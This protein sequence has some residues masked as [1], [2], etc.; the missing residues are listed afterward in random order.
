MQIKIFMKEN[1]SF[2]GDFKVRNN[3]KQSTK[4]DKAKEY[5]EKY[6]DCSIRRMLPTGTIDYA[7][8][9]SDIHYILFG[10]NLPFRD[11]YLMEVA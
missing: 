8:G 3:A 6:Y 7:T 2:M 10:E 11:I 9:T 4:L 1:N 5:I